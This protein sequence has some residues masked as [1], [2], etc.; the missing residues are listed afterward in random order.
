MPSGVGDFA[1][2]VQSWAIAPLAAGASIT[3]T[4]VV[5][6]PSGQQTALLFAQVDSTGV[7]DETDEGNNI[8]SSGTGACLVAADGFENDNL[9]S[10]AKPLASGASQGHSFGGPG[11]QDWMLLDAQPGHAYQFTT[12]N[13]APSVD[14]RL[15]IYGPDG[16]TLL[17]SNDDADNTTLASQLFWVPPAPGPFYLVAQ[18]WNPGLGGCGSFYTVS[19]QDLG[20]GSVTFLPM[21]AR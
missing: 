7:V 19:A 1:G 2:S 14:T 6:Q 15:S 21:L 12:S 16:L 9:R 17:A 10:L 5:P 8:W 11:D 4:G 13:L 18:D 20:P 3:V